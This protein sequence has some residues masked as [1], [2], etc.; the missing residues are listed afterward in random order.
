MYRFSLNAFNIFFLSLIFWHLI[1]TCLGVIF[2]GFSCSLYVYG[3][4]TCIRFGKILAFFSYPFPLLSE[5]DP[6]YLYVILIVIFFCQFFSLSVFQMVVFHSSDFKLTNLFS[7]VRH[8]PL[9][10]PVN[11]SIWTLYCLASKVHS[12]FFFNIFKFPHCVYIFKSLVCSFNMKI[13][14]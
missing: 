8:L 10:L 9:S 2:F 3:F 6:N 12:L 5:W 7:A 14:N 4:I 1:A 11:F 13:S